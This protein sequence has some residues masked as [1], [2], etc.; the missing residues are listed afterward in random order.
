MKKIASLVRLILFSALALA[1]VLYCSAVFR[2]KKTELPNDTTNKIEGFYALENNSM[3]V[4]FLG[5]SHTYYGF[6]PSVL[7]MKT[8]LSSYVFA[9]ECQPASVTYHYLK[10]AL[11][12]Q[13][14]NLIVI[15]VFSLLP[16]SKKCQTSGIIKKNVEDFKFSKNKIDALQMIENENLWENLFD[17]SIYKDRWNEIGKDDLLY[18]LTS[19]F[20]ENFGYT[21]GYPADDP[22]Y[23]REPYNSNETLVPDK[24]VL[25]SLFQIFHLAREQ[26]IDVLVVK[27][28]YYK[29]EEEHKIINYIFEKTNEFGFNTLDFNQIYDELDFVFDKDG[30]VWHCNVR[31]AWKITNYLSDYILNHYQLELKPSSYDEQYRLLYNKTI[32]HMLWTYFDCKEY[33]DYLA[34]LD[35]T[36]LINYNGKEEGW[37]SDENWERLHRIGI[38]T[39][40]L[41][42]DY[43]AVI[44]GKETYFEHFSNLMLDNEVLV[45]ENI[46]KCK[47]D[48]TTYKFVYN[49]EEVEYNHV[50]LNVI[51]I[52]NMTKTVMDRLAF[53]V[54]NDLS[55]LRY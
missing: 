50:S 33:L 51:V 22:I 26:D 45:G 2:P 38:P 40:D 52:D 4:L 13:S 5:T 37:I 31:G 17:I 15:D 18:P 28:P 23:V 27:T 8:G 43:A 47:S 46:I 29:T 48:G 54:Q 34:T 53:D 20:N 6:N 41:Y 16:S 1:I 10:E 39:F 19:H 7:Y 25:T 11:K 30:D 35:V 12:T 49:G 3:D 24:E 42:S 55:I 44:S 36:L 32:K 9:G 21:E 14:P